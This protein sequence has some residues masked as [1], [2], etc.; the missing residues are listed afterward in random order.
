[1]MT[2][3]RKIGIAFIVS[4]CCFFLTLILALQFRKER[5]TLEATGI[6]T[7]GIVTNTY[8]AGSRYSDCFHIE[9]SFIKGDTILDGL[10]SFS[11]EEREQ[12]EK[13]VI[14]STYMVRFFSNKPSKT[15]R[16]YIDEPVSVSEKEYQRLLERVWVTRKRIDRSKTWW[17]NF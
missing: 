10:S 7:V 11:L 4:A 2:N 13:A 17:K 8:I 12:L 16:I 3:K 9:F 6:E 14:G 1:M 5:K 15:A